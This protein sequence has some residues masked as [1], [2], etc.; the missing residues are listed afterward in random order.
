MAQQKHQADAAFLQA[1][2]NRKITNMIH[3]RAALGSNLRLEAGGERVGIKLVT[4]NS[5]SDQR[6]NLPG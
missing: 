4:S 5:A 6:L 1:R 2:A 3:R